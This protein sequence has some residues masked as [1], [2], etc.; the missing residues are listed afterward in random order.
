MYTLIADKLA[1]AWN[2]LKETVA[3]AFTIPVA[4]RATAA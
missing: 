1:S 3:S 2:G 4:V